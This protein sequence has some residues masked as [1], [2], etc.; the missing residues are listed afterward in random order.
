MKAPLR[1]VIDIAYV[2]ACRYTGYVAKT[3]WL[4]LECGHESFRK[5]SAGA[6]KR[7]RCRECMLGL[8]GQR[9]S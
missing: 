3:I 9:S 1:K 2:G 8:H 4:K 5:A 7:A 6:P